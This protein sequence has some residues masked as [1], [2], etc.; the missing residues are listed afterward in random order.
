MHLEPST[1]HVIGDLSGLEKVTG[2][3]NFKISYECQTVSVNTL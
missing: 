1:G 2:S 3:V